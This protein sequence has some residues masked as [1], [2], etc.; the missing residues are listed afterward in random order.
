MRAVAAGLLV[1]AFVLFIASELMAPTY[2]V[3]MLRAGAEAALVGGLADWFA[4]VALFRKPMGLPIPHTAIIPKNKNRIA[5]NLGEFVQ[6]KFLSPDAL[7]KLIADSCPAESFAEWI[8]TPQ[9]ARRIGR[10]AAT[11]VDAWLDFIDEKQIQELFS[12]AYVALVSK[13]DVSQSAASIL[14]TLTTGA[15]HQELLDAALDLVK[16]KLED[17][18]LRKTIA[19]RIAD[20]LKQEHKL[21][22]KMLPTEWLSEQAAQAAANGIAKFLAEVSSS[23]KHEL[24]GAFDSAL[25]RLVAKLRTD[26][27]FLR[28]G[29]ELKTLLLT[30][31]E[32]LTYISSLWHSLRDW[33]SQDLESTTPAMSAQVEKMGRWIGRKLTDDGELVASINEHIVKYASAAAPHFAAFLTKHI[34]QTIYRWNEEEMSEQIELSIG[35]D[36]QYIRLSGTAVG[37]V[38]G[39]A[40]FL[41]SDLLGHLQLFAIH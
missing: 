20:W 30:S 36:L 11:A 31:P 28:K 27:E 14:E 1:L 9:N 23:P 22:E 8:S 41:V 16:A 40:L 7:A 25:N 12:D 33:L 5:D 39:A 38:I 19:V 6:E 10:Y 17:D 21:K 13:L 24:R 37:A 15:R 26:E 18:D 2:A 3:R 32:A 29:E 4:V 35:P 34:R